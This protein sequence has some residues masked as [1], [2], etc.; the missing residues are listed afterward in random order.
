M[1]IRH[2]PLSFLFFLVS[3]TAVYGQTGQQDQMNSSGDGMSTPEHFSPYRVFYENSLC[4]VKRSSDNAII[5]PATY[6][7]ITLQEDTDLML[8][9]NENKQVGLFN[10]KKNAFLFPISYKNIQISARID[11]NGVGSRQKIELV[12]DNQLYELALLQDDSVITLLS[13]LNAVNTT[14]TQDLILLTKGTKQGM[15]SVSANRLVLPITYDTIAGLDNQTY[16]LPS[17]N[18]LFTVRKAQKTGVYS[19]SDQLLVP[20]I[21]DSISIAGNAIIGW[22]KKSIAVYPN[23]EA[24]WKHNRPVKIQGTKYFMGLQDKNGKWELLRVNQQP[25]I[26]KTPFD[27]LKIIPK[28]NYFDFSGTDDVAPILAYKGKDLYLIRSFDTL[29]YRVFKDAMTIGLFKKNLIY[30][31]SEGKHGIYSYQLEEIMPCKFD[32][33]I[34]WSGKKRSE[35][36]WACKADKYWYF[37]EGTTLYD[38]IQADSIRLNSMNTFCASKNGKMALV[39]RSNNTATDFIYDFIEFKPKTEEKLARIDSVYVYLS[40]NGTTRP[41]GK[42]I[43]YSKDG[44]TSQEAV[45]EAFLEAVTSSNDSLLYTFAEKLSPDY[46]SYEFMNY[47]QADYRD[48]FNNFSNWKRKEMLDRYYSKLLLIKAKMMRQSEGQVIKNKGFEYA[49]LRKAEINALL[50]LWGLESVMLFQIGDIKDYRVNLG[51]LFLVDGYFKV[52]TLPN[53]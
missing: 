31:S 52:F 9:Y 47:R 6:K 19:S 2:T 23:G 27:S 24:T 44:Y 3:L 53:P 41:A 11:G 25:L 39:N 13:G 10:P 42:E 20:E 46:N 28:S 8:V 22:T 17:R 32:Q 51:E 5:L 50:T 1:K 43:S 45:T 15:F 14:Y 18:Q 30:L 12:T 49:K 16:Q 48:H 21:Y 38:S 35:K 36:Q 33:I 29:Q 34:P 7:Y 4:G 26:D 37:Y 40:L